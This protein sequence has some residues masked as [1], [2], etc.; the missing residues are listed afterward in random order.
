MLRK[1]EIVFTEKENRSININY[2]SLFHGLLMESI[3]SADANRLHEN[4]LRPF[5]QYLYYSKELNRWVWVINTLSEEMD[6]IIYKFL[7]NQ[8]QLKLKNKD[9]LIDI[10]YVKEYPIKSYSDLTNEVYSME[11]KRNISLDF[12]TPCSFKI[13][14]NNVIYPEIKY[15]YNTILNRWNS[16][17]DV[18][19]INDKEAIEH[20]I[21]HT[22]IKA[23]N[24]CSKSYSLESIFVKGFDGRMTFGVNG[25]EPL[26]NLSNLMFRFAEYSGLGSR[27]ALGM[28]GIRV[29]L[30]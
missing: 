9:L 16:F 26:V 23:F 6:N 11:G 20:I 21:N 3:D 27:T 8:N 13:S 12:L 5:S 15:F 22:Y 10:D 17:S 18:V 24:I 7:N 28:G 29:E 4:S 19:S 2:G 30:K 1:R 14:G 25:P